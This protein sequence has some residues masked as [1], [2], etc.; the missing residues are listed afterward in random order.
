MFYIS[1]ND[2]LKNKVVATLKVVVRDNLDQP[3]HL[4]NE[5]KS[6]SIESTEYDAVNN[7]YFFRT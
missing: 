3:A 6:Y 5:K 7:L 2:F 4:C 1:T